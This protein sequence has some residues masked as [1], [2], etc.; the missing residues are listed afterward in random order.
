MPGAGRHVPAPSDACELLTHDT[1]RLVA[2]TGLGELGST[3]SCAASGYFIGEGGIVGEG[4][5]RACSSG[6]CCSRGGTRTARASRRC[7]SGTWWLGSAP[8]YRSNTPPNIH[9]GAWRASGGTDAGAVMTRRG[10]MPRL[11]RHDRFRRGGLDAPGRISRL[12]R[13]DRSR[14]NPALGS[15]G[16]GQPPRSVSLLHCCCTQAN[17]PT[18]AQRVKADG[19]A[20]FVVP[21]SRRRRRRPTRRPCRAS[22]TL[23]AAAGTAARTRAR[24]CRG[25]GRRTSARARAARSRGSPATAGASA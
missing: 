3:W 13:H 8:A 14:L 21:H 17:A 10:R 6:T 24:R 15:Q 23:A 16:P 11:A 25:S 7:S 5:V 20:T 9:A 12:A 18:T 22:A 2:R 1:R 4:S 19:Y